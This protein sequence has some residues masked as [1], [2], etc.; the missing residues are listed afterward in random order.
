MSTVTRIANHTPSR[1][2]LVTAPGESRVLEVT[3]AGVAVGPGDKLVVE[4]PGAGGNG[5]PSRRNPRRSAE[6]RRSGKLSEAYLE[7]HDGAKGE[8]E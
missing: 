5:R 3:P 4:T 7:A 8:A 1:P 6:D 2:R